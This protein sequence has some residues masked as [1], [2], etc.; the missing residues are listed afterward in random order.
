MPVKTNAIRLLDAA[1]V[2]YRLLQ[3]SL[4][5]ASLSGRA[6]FGGAVAEALGLEP[7]R[8]FKSLVTI[9]T[10]GPVFAV[11]PASS[12]LDL[13]LLAKVRQERRMSLAP[14]ADVLGLTGY[15][16]GAVTV[17]GAKKK[18]PVVVD[19]LATLRDHIAVS[20]GAKG[21]QVELST[22][23]YLEITDAVVA[24]ISR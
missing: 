13:K 9:G 17:L 1:G 16:R 23:T 7:D 8:I 21:L 3:Y 20:G 4:P 18:F 11:L 19:E 15:R 10:S 24:D 12:E 22:T 6:S 14:R 5:D 2:D